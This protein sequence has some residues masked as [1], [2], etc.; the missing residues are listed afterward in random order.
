MYLGAVWSTNNP[1]S[2]YN[3]PG[4][5]RWGCNKVVLPSAWNERVRWGWESDYKESEKEI[6]MLKLNRGYEG[7]V[8]R[9]NI[10]RVDYIKNLPCDVIGVV[11][12]DDDDEIITYLVVTKNTKGELTMNDVDRFL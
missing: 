5:A 9:L 2:C 11:V 12:D 7:L 1:S 10:E 8:E 4:K 3:V 6:E